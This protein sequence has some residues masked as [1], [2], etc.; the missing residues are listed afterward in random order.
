MEEGIHAPEH[1]ASAPEMGRPSATRVAPGK[2]T[3]QAH[4]KPRL[5]KLSKYGILGVLAVMVRVGMFYFFSR[6]WP[7]DERLHDLTDTQR[8]WNHFIANGQ[9]FF[10][11]NLVA[12]VGN[13]LWVFEGGRHTRRREFVYFTLVSLIGWGIGSL[14]GPGMIALFGISA[15]LGLFNVIAVSLVVNYWGRRHLVFLR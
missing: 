14:F 12:Y 9:A 5:W 1:T 8:A 11:S 10:F 13:A 7:S 6:W 2:S 4:W 15:R 3:L